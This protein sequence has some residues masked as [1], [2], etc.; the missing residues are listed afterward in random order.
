MDL[1]PDPERRMSA[2]SIDRLPIA[3]GGL[4]RI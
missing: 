1:E 2:A 4:S 3:N